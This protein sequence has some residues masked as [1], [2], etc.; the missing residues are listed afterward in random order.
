MELSF[1]LV[2]VP[3]HL[4]EKTECSL[5]L[6]H[7]LDPIKMSSTNSSLFPYVPPAHVW[8]ACTNIQYVWL[9]IDTFIFPVLDAPMYH[10][11]HGW[12]CPFLTNLGNKR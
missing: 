2:V 6:P 5:E 10:W 4:D 8:T 9:I 12:S 1:T 3:R 11:I 7:Q